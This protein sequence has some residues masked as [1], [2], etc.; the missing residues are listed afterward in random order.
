MRSITFKVDESA[1]FDVL[2]GKPSLQ[3]SL[4]SRIVSALLTKTSFREDI[5]LAMYGIT[6][7]EES[8]EKNNV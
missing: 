8:Q 4:G 7:T 3:E 5:G 1:L 2:A 6:V